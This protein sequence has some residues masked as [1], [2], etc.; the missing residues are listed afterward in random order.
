MVRRARKKSRS[1]IYHIIMRG[2]NRQTI[3]EEEEDRN[4]FL[5]ILKKYKTISE[6]KIHSYCL[7]DN[8]IHLLWEESEKECLAN[9]IKRI[10]SSYVYWYNHKYE[11]SGHLFQERFKSENVES[12]DYFLTVL[13]YI[14]QNPL[15]AGI[16]NNISE[17]KWTSYHEYFS[18]GD[19]VDTE[20]GLRLYAKEKTK[21]VHLY[22]EH[23]QQ[24]ND[25]QCL[26]IKVKIIKTDQEVRNYLY[27]LGVYNTSSLQQMDK[28]DRDA[29]LAKIKMMEG[30]SLRQLER[31][32]G[33]SKSV[34]G[35]ARDGGT[36]QLS[37]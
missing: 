31:I 2:V 5:E 25:D 8:H 9:S 16:A 28:K 34:I 22:L 27:Q 36:G 37:R 6:Y 19:L 21:A 1:G 29:I 7:M 3:F 32:T 17:C 26:D 24:I 35:R 11:R 33:I 23:M 14:H 18:C 12:A 30:T 20:L 4:R 15:K 10:S 13:R